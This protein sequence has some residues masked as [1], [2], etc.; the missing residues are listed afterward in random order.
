MSILLGALI[1][2]ADLLDLVDLFSGPLASSKPS[3]PILRRDWWP[4]ERISDE[5]DG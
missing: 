3:T 2:I 5:S 4:P 1:C